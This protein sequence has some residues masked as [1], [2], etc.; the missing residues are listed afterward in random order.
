[1]AK[2][3]KRDWIPM[4]TVQD[5]HGEY[6][7]VYEEH[8]ISKTSDF[9][10]LKGFPYG[11]NPQNSYYKSPIYILAPDLVPYLRGHAISES[12]KILGI[13]KSVII[14]MRKEAG[15][16]K[17]RFKVDLQ[18]VLD[19]KEEIL[20]APFSIL[21][22]KYGF[23]RIQVLKLVE[24][25]NTHAYSKQN[26]KPRLTIYEYEQQQILQQ[27]QGYDF[28]GLSV[29]EIQEKTQKSRYIAQKIYD[30]IAKE[31]NKPS[32]SEEYHQQKAKQQK[33]MIKNK[34]KILA[35]DK[36]I[37]SIAKQL[38][39]TSMQ[40]VRMRAL[41]RKQLNIV[42]TKKTMDEW[43]LENQ[44]ILF[45]DLSIDEIAQ[46]VN[47]SPKKTIE[48]RSRLRR[49]LNMP[50]CN[51]II[52][53]WRINNKSLLLSDELSMDEIAK[54]IGKTKQ[55]VAKQRLI[56]RREFNIDVKQ[57]HRQWLLDHQNELLNI[58]PNILSKKYNLHPETIKNRRKKLE[59]IL[60]EQK[61]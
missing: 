59:K 38:N 37:E 19:N 35:K 9:R 32:F 7:D 5:V 60:L 34:D 42:E 14:N 39:K 12:S 3:F 53:E 21:N 10:V 45:S 58:S 47:L 41:L 49:L 30:K 22:R 51:D 18:W 23:S 50:K 57:Q 6:W 55:Y 43:A 8:K 26:E 46:K 61:E 2:K 11:H 33:W 20:S 17:P 40:I 15:L 1:M 52:H 54:K 29:D 36:T 48:Y 16:T 4:Y 28:T 13:S 31:N 27:L 25:I 56:L 24:L 44:D